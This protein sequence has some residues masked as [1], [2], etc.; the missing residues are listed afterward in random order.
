M[1]LKEIDK[2]LIISSM[3]I[4]ENKTGHDIGPLLATHTSLREMENTPFLPTGS[5]VARA[6]RKQYIKTLCFIGMGKTGKIIFSYLENEAH[7]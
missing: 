7:L 6:L 4:Y 2:Y 1:L 5:F 3:N